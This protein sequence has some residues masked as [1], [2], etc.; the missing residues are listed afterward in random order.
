MPGERERRRSAAATCKGARPHHD[1]SFSC[2]VVTDSGQELVDNFPNWL[3]LL[4][5]NALPPHLGTTVERLHVRVTPDLFET[6]GRFS[7]WI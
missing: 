4:Q 6:H 5:W 2:E 7:L 1:R 3:L